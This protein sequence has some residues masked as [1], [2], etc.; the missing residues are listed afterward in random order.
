MESGETTNYH[1][2]SEREGKTDGENGRVQEGTGVVLTALVHVIEV[3]VV[4]A[5]RGREEGEKKKD[6]SV[7]QH[8]EQHGCTN[9]RM[10]AHL[11]TCAECR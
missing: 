4:A 10:P 1:R 6:C 3:R 11:G 2:E 8:S 9:G 7:V 5:W